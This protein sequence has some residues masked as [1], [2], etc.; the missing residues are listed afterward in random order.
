MSGFKSFRIVLRS[1]I[2]LDG[3]FGLLHITPSCV[4]QWHLYFRTLLLTTSGSFPGHRTTLLLLVMTLVFEDIELSHW[5]LLWS[6]EFHFQRNKAKC[7][8]ENYPP[9]FSFFNID[10]LVPSWNW[11]NERLPSGVIFIL[12]FDLF[13]FETDLVKWIKFRL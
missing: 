4:F 5:T 10:C 6:L 13:N 1:L 12:S 9:S 7:V 8:T 2:F 3:T 11:Y